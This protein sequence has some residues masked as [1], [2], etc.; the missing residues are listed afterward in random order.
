MWYVFFY[1]CFQCILFNPS[2]VISSICKLKK[3]IRFVGKLH[4]TLR[5]NTLIR[6]TKISSH[7]GQL[8]KYLGHYM[9]YR[10]Y[11]HFSVIDSQMLVRNN[12]HKVI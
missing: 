9:L 1:T 3:V 2:L 6:L 10:C 11:M 5:V 8:L 12:T 7:V 4:S